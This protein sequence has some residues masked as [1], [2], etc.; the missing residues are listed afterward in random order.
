[1]SKLSK[2]GNIPNSECSDLLVFDV[3]VAELIRLAI[4]QI[5]A[6][7]SHSNRSICKAGVDALLRLSEHGKQSNVL[8]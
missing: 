4:P 3:P 1:L 6:L 7:L 8:I 2:Q 5:V